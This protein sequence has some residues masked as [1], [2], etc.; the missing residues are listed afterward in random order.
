VAQVLGK[1][2]FVEVVLSNAQDT[3]G[4]YLNT[5]QARELAAGRGGRVDRRSG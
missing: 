4:G 3:A 5:A 1:P 2:A